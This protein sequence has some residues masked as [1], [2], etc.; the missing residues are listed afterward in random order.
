MLG[1]PDA[2]ILQL[3]RML[4]LPSPVSAHC[5]RLD[6][7]WKPLHGHPRFEQLLTVR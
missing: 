5:L 4:S 3:E 1:K 6:P 7:I 2:A